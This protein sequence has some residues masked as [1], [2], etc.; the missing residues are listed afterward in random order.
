MK[1]PWSKMTTEEIREYKRKLQAD[2]RA[3]LRALYPGKSLRAIKEEE[4]KKN[5]KK[6]RK[7]IYSKEQC[8]HCGIV[9]K[10]MPSHNCLSSVVFISNM[11]SYEI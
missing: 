3:R 2:K 8:Q 7:Q 4:D 1:K 9:L 5:G 6:E 10:L 11:V